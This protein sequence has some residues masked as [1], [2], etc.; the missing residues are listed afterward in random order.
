MPSNPIPAPR[1][2]RFPGW[3]AWLRR[4]ALF[5][6]LWWILTDGARDSWLIGGPIVFLAAW[7]SQ[8]LWAP[9]PLSLAGLARFAPW[10]AWQSLVGATDVAMRALQPQMPLRPGVVHHSL[11]L[12]PGAPR[13][14]LANVVSM[15]AGTL[16]VDLVGEQLVIHAL[17]TGKDLHAMV[18]DLEPR[19][20]AV[21]DCSLAPLTPVRGRDVAP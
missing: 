20:A 7:L 15:L 12:P 14:A 11:R 5:A 8:A 10:F 13:V 17:D 18:V 4:I 1:A 2:W 16:S 19:I 21:F 9:S 6:A 3:P